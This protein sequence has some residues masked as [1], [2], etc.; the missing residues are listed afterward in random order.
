VRAD[1]CKS[2]G[3][4]PLTKYNTGLRK[5]QE[6]SKIL[7]KIS[8]LKDRNSR[9][10]APLLTLSPAELLPDYDVSDSNLTRS[11]L[12]D[13]LKKIHDCAGLLEFRTHFVPD[14]TGD[15][16]QRFRIHNATYCR[17]YTVCEICSRRVQL[18]RWKRFR[19]PVENLV[20]KYPHVYHVTFTIEDK[21]RL[22]ER[23]DFLQSAF[24]N[25]V[26]MGQKRGRKKSLGEWS[27]V[28]AAIVATENKRGENSDLWHSHKHALLF[29]R[30]PLSY[31]VYDPDKLRRLERL[32][33]YRK[34]PKHAMREAALNL[35]K[36]QGEM[37]PASKLSLEWLK[38]T[39]GQGISVHARRL[40]GNVA[41]VAKEVLKYPVKVALK[42]Q[43]DIPYIIEQTYNRRFLSTYGDLRGL[44][45][46][47]YE[48]SETADSKEIYL[49]QWTG[50]KY[51]DL[52]PGRPIASMPEEVRKKLFSRMA[53]A[54]GAYRRQRREMRKTYEFTKI[55]VLGVL[56]ENLDRLKSEYRA[57]IAALVAHFAKMPE[58]SPRVMPFYSRSSRPDAEPLKLCL[59]FP[60]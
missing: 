16:E 41:D 11:D 45:T 49:S 4:L 60:A 3:T 51:S 57:G 59:D 8:R 28:G 32:Y 13:K 42:S 21:A 5:V 46:E 29:C 22:G 31:Q 10:Y 27:K 34:V 50:Y 7:E 2:T 56:A 43:A 36:F 47:E 1:R 20:G 12:H 26:R 18:T 55:K 15:L 44:P 35:V 17:H 52:V 9:L 38:A 40:R 48:D 25:F 19:E 39:A 37:V 58:I 24:R 23:I 54:T 14:S 33:G 6:L 30:K 53:K